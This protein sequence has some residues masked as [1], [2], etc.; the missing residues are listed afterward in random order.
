MSGEIHGLLEN[1]CTVLVGLTFS[2]QMQ[3]HTVYW[4]LC[5]PHDHQKVIPT[6]L[7]QSSP[8]KIYQPCS[9]IFLLCE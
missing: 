1:H 4:T 2:T 7:Y 8:S 9:S 5:P 6:R 3:S